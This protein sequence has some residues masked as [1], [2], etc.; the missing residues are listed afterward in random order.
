MK[1]QTAAWWK[2]QWELSDIC[3]DGDPENQQGIRFCVFQMHQTLHSA[4]NSAVV[5]AKGLTGEAYTGNTFGDTEVYCLPFYL[6]NNPAAA[7]NIMKFRYDTLPEAKRRA[8]ML[9]LAGAYYPVATIAGRECCDLWQHANLQMHPSTSVMFGIWLYVKLT[10]DKDFLYEMG[11]EML[12]EICRMLATRGAYG[13]DGGYGFY[14][15]MGLDEF[16]MMVN[17][18][19]YTNYMAKKSFAYTKT[20][21][22]EMQA[23]RPEDYTALIKR[24]GLGDSE[25]KDWAE[26]AAAMK[27]CYDEQSLLYEQHDGF[28][29]LPHTDL[30]AIPAEQFPLYAHWSYERIYRS[31]MIKQPDV[32]M[33]MLLY[34]SEFTDEQLAA[35]YDFYEPRCIHESSLSPSVHSILAAQVGRHKQA[36]DFFGFATRMDLDNY[37]RNTCEGLHTTSIAGA[38]MNIVYG[39]GGLRS[40]GESLALTPT[41]PAGWN[42]YSF[43]L[44][45]GGCVVGV[46]VTPEEVRLT[47]D[48]ECGL[49]LYGEPLRLTKTG[50]IAKRNN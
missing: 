27:D 42:A 7:K 19:A 1:A 11:A 50:H 2:R 34:S 38:W 14:G 26:K 30:A 33:F 25:L 37:N 48:G 5:G 35:N 23:E 17:N 3:I 39:F 22:T 12:V 24:L 31:D 4:E 8:A 44:L 49:T 9:D 20:A 16:H 18:N 21:L 10:G 13:P 6:F 46:T 15:V 45:I 29:D 40:D 47:C 41:I 43:K 28:Y 32:L 36:Y